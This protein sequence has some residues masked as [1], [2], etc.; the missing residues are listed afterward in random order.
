ML[1]I[2]TQVKTQNIIAMLSHPVVSANRR[3]GKKLAKEVLVQLGVAKKKPHVVTR[4]EVMAPGA[5][6][7]DDDLGSD[8]SST[9]SLSSSSLA[10]M[11]GQS[12]ERLFGTMM[13]QWLEA[14]LL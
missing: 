3:I 1:D 7:L 12:L 8:D 14:R 13:R 2:E 11:N 9:G 6:L 4:R 10:S 5:Q